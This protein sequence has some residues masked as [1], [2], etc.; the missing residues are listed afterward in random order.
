MLFKYML[1]TSPITIEQ[2]LQSFNLNN[3]DFHPANIMWKP[4]PSSSSSS[5]LGPRPEN[6]HNLVLLDW[7][8]V[9]LGSGAQ[10][11]GQYF[12]S[13][14][15]PNQRKEIEERMVRLYYNQL[16]S[17][18]INDHVN[19]SLHYSWEMCWNEYIYG[20][21][22]KWIWLLAILSSMLPDPLMQY[23]HDQVEAFGHD[24]HVTPEKVNMPRL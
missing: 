9:G 23:F 19:E 13:H 24:H 8:L 14:L 6:S 12:I 16:L 11:V 5:S 1:Q 18:G 10:D 17:Y 2:L 21:I 15:Y 3:S 20:G 7:E 4:D 22:E